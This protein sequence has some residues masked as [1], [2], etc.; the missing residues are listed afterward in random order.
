MSILFKPYCRETFETLILRVHF[1]AYRFQCCH[2]EK[3]LHVVLS[4]NDS[5]SER[6]TLKKIIR[7]KTV[8]DPEQTSYS[9]TF[10][11]RP[12]SP[13]LCVAFIPPRRDSKYLIYSCG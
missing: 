8:C 3:Q 7:G 9:E 10:E 13:N 4:K 12:L 5:F 6:I 1:N 2:A 11:K